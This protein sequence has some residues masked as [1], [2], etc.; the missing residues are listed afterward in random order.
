MLIREL[1][2]AD[3]DALV[4]LALRAWEPV[5]ASVRSILRPSGVYDVQ[6]PDGW[7]AAQRAAV[8][9]VCAAPADARVAE[10]D[11]AVVGFVAVAMRDEGL[12]E[13]DIL[14]V[15]PAAQRRGIG[16]ALTRHAFDLLAGRGATSVMVETGGDPGHAPARAVYAAAGFV[17]WPVSRWFRVTGDAP[18]TPAG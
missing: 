17:E 7:A 8:E 10:T 18:V 1:D 9:R 2:P 13:I 15:D 16:T 11:G 3:R 14:A 5:F 6:Y 4:A 12:G